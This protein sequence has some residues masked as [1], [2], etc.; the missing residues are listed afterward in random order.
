[1]KVHLLRM[2]HNIGAILFV[3]GRLAIGWLPKWFDVIDANDLII[4]GSLL[5]AYTVGEM[6]MSSVQMTFVANIAP[7]HLRRTYM[8]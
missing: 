3:V 6:I 4:L 7:E 5:I 1:M 2:A 8:Q